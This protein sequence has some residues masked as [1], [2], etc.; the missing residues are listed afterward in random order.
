MLV[1]VVYESRATA[2][3]KVHSEDQS[4]NAQAEATTTTTTTLSCVAIVLSLLLNG[5]HLI[6]LA[7]TQ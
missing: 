7:V 3:Q 6:S 4:E 5:N 2:S 1:C